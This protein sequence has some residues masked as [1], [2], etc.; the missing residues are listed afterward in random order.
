MIDNGMMSSN[1]D[2]WETPQDFFDEYNK[3]YNFDVDVCALP[4]NAKVD[5]F[6]TPGDNA[7]T[8]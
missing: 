3:K 8:Q 7:L 4:C 2:Q 6:Y 5:K 1:T